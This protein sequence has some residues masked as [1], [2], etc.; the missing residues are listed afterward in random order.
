[1]APILG[2][3]LS[4]IPILTIIYLMPFAAV[5][6]LFFIPGTNQKAVKVTSLVF[7]VIS[8]VLSI[9]LFL[10]YD[11]NKGGFQFIEHH[12]WAAS[13]GIN[14][15]MAVNGI[16]VT[17]VLLTG[18]IITAGVLA[19]WNVTYRPKEFFILLLIL[20][21]GVFGVF[22]TYNLFLFFL[23]YEIAVLPMYVL[24]GI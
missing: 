5:M 1:M 3:I 2:E 18:I 12:V 6:A 20:T 10:A 23:F 9:L 13:I 7:S 21:T 4:R 14:Y 24:I 8:L 16:N 11:Y 15:F 19:S 22:M 17:L